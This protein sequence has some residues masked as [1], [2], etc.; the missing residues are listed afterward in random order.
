[1]I[2]ESIIGDR[3][4]SNKYERTENLELQ[5]AVYPSL[6]LLTNYQNALLMFVSDGVRFWRRVPGESSQ[7]TIFV[8]WPD[9]D[10]WLSYQRPVRWWE[11]FRITFHILAQRLTRGQVHWVIYK[12]PR[13]DLGYCGSILTSVLRLAGTIHYENI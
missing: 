10:N 1:M 3:L 11:T 5:A 8:G 12:K 2:A 7:L 9:K 13:T 6:K 4:I